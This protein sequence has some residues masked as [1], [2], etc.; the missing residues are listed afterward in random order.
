MKARVL[1]EAGLSFLCLCLIVCAAF[2]IPGADEMR[3]E[4]STGAF[5]SLILSSPYLGYIVIGTLSFALGVC[6]TLLCLHLRAKEKGE[7]TNDD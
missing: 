7:K 2:F 5:G 6:L 1:R 4:S 3:Q